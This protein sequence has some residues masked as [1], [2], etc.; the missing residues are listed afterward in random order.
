[1]IKSGFAKIVR[2]IWPGKDYVIFQGATLP[3]AR[4]RWCG[5]E[6]KDDA[7]YLQS[8]EAEARRLVTRFGLTPQSRVLDVGCGQGR[9]AIGLLKVGVELDYTGLDVSRE[10]IAWCQ[11][12]LQARHPRF[13]FQFLDVANERYHQTGQALAPGFRFDFPDRSFDIIY[14][15][16]VLSHLREDDMR[17]YLSDFRR[18]LAPDGRLFFTAFVEENVPPVSINP[19]GYIFP[20]CHGPLHVVRYEQSHLLAALRDAGFSLIEL[21]HATEADRQS[22]VTAAL[23]QP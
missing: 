11:R 3:A 15:F 4:M 16:S 2:K 12:R 17:L 13:R 10:S 8:A 6:F 1:M 5:P 23:A 21:T 9:L 22:T 14:L 7:F 20:Q 18:L 19:E